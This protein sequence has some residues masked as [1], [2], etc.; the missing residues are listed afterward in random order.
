MTLPSVRTW[1]LRTPYRTATR[2]DCHR[3]RAMRVRTFEL[4]LI[5]VALVVCWSIAAGLVLLADEHEVGGG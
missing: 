4:R 5:A 1:Y 2:T 3:L